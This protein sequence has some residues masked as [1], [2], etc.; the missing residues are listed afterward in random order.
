ML[1][2]LIKRIL[3]PNTS[4]VEQAGE[5]YCKATL[6]G[7][8]K[9]SRTVPYSPQA[10]WD[11]EL[12]FEV[13]TALPRN[14]PIVVSIHSRPPVKTE[15]SK[16]WKVEQ[17]SLVGAVQIEMDQVYKLLDSA[18][19]NTFN[20]HA[21]SDGLA[22]IGVYNEQNH[23]ANIVLR[24]KKVGDG[25]LPSL[26]AAEGHQSMDD[27]VKKL[28][29]DAG[30]ELRYQMLEHHD[31]TSYASKPHNLELRRSET[32][33]KEVDKWASKEEKRISRASHRIN[34]LIGSK[35][36]QGELFKSKLEF[37]TMLQTLSEL[38]G[39]T[40]QIGS[41]AADLENMTARL[42]GIQEARREVERAL[43]FSQSVCLTE[44]SPSLEKLREEA[45]DVQRQVNSG[46]T[47]LERLEREL[48][49]IPVPQ[50]TS[51]PVQVL[52]LGLLLL[53][54]IMLWRYFQHSATLKAT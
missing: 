9:T 22:G 5:V 23:R 34:E 33:Y 36:Q 2:N 21:S 39:V 3:T 18:P 42:T 49:E 19:P 6:R 12:A 10:T 38:Q 44:I 20:L 7:K 47:N 25:D 15:D 53:L 32:F 31:S 26:S 54:I 50:P 13:P 8:V 40:N 52:R 17:D 1:Q 28:T 27:K 45:A 35:N 41:T 16:E 30:D 48:N 37:Q 29:M 14:T 4:P 24:F 11:T 51:R 46:K 43:L